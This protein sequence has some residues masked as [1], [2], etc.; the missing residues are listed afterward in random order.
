MYYQK[1]LSRRS[2]LSH[3]TERFVYFKNTDLSERFS[4]N[5]LLYKSVPSLKQFQEDMAF[6]RR[7]QADYSSRYVHFHFPE[8]QALPEELAQFLRAEHF[9]VSEHLIFWA[10]VDRLKLSQKIPQK[11][12]VKAMDASLYPLYKAVSSP[13]YLD[14]SKAYSQQMAGYNYAFVENEQ[15][16]LFLALTGQKII[17]VM[18]AWYSGDIV[19]MDGFEVAESWRHQGV[20]SLLQKAS[21]TNGVA[22]AILIAEEENRPLY[23]HQGFQ[24]VAYYIDAIKIEPKE[25]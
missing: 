25:S 22:K 6:L 21:L 5:Y 3:E 24:Q 2:R 13:Y 7:E 23:E 20:G 1:V 14:Y 12:E 17:G 8:N 4:E 10:E 11:V 15:A 18:A 19:E 9:Q 16:S